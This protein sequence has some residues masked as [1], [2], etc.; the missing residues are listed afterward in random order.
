MR[1]GFR[2]W[3]ISFLRFLRRRLL[4][5]GFR[6]QLQLLRG[7]PLLVG[8]GRMHT[9]IAPSAGLQIKG[10]MVQAKFERKSNVE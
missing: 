6:L 7:R 5:L 4:L 9:P 2:S 10:N 1:F 8:L 3:F